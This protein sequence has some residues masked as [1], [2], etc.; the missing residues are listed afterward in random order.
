MTGNESDGSGRERGRNQWEAVFWDI[1]GVIL[2][3]ESVQAAHASFV[4]DLVDRHDLELSR[5]QAL[6]TWRTT[7]GDYFR[8]RDGTEF[9]SAREG[10]ARAVDALVGEDVPREEWKPTFE[11][12]VS[13]SIEPIPGAPETIERLTERDFHVGVISDVDDAEGKRMLERFGV[14]SQ[15]DS[16]TTS[17]EVGRTKPDPAMF[18]TALEKAEVAPERSLMIGDRY[19][20][21]V[22]GASEAG[23]HGVAFGA[24]EGPA[25]SYRIEDPREVLEIVDG[26]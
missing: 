13:E 2:E 10:Y 24:D 5:Q 20:H 18:E 26:E 25:V 17:E 11:A 19:E 12:A 1:G 3:L 21:D 22:K 9:R 14:R 16:I 7:V 6:E 8:D 4:A 15:F 23:L